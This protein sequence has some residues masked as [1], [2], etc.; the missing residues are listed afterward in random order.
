MSLEDKILEDVHKTGSPTEI[1]AAS[2]MRSRG[3]YV[4]HNPSYLDDSEGR[5]REF[6]IRAYRGLSETISDRRYSVGI[7]LMVECKKSEKPWVF[8]TT[9]ADHGD[10]RLGSLIISSL[11][12]QQVFT[13]RSHSESIIS[14]AELR[15]FHHYFRQ[16]RLAR[17]FCQPF[18]GTEKND[19]SPMIY[20]A[21]MSAVKATLFHWKTR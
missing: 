2:L 14:D 19:Y 16:T 6:D 21:I 15:D 8:F 10:V 3:W 9:P 12:K 4:L 7:Y 13:D 20:S 1:I 17:T 5:S 18:K 11:E